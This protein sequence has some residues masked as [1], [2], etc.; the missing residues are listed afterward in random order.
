MRSITGYRVTVSS[1]RLARVVG[2]VPGLAVETAAS[3]ES[4]EAGAPAPDEADD[5]LRERVPLPEEGA[6]SAV[7][8]YGLLGL[9]ASM[10]ALGIATVG[11]WVYRR[12]KSDSDETPPPAS[13]VGTVEPS[14]S[15]G[16][17]PST[18]EAG[19]IDETGPSPDET[20]LSI[21]TPDD[22]E[23]PPFGRTEDRT[24][25]EWTTRDRTEAADEDETVDETEPGA[26]ADEP[27]TGDDETTRAGESVDV[28]PLLGVAFVAVSGAV[29]R[30]LQGDED[31]QGR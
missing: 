23:G 10:I 18:G 19:E 7:K 28:A 27:E 26:T 22:E 9:G 3:E 21:V 13:E 6:A 1:D 12:R 17:T 8:R 30:W 5:G 2:A 25:V 31:A 29:V 20:E 16:P 14:P 15:P 11:L 24:D 4:D